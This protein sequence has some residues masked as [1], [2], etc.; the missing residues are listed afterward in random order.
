[1]ALVWMTDNGSLDKLG[2]CGDREKDHFETYFR[3]SNDTT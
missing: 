2:S 3:D 1:M